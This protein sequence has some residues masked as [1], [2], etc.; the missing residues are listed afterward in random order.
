VSHCSSADKNSLPAASLRCSSTNERHLLLAIPQ[1][2]SSPALPFYSCQRFAVS[3]QGVIV[4]LL[5]HWN[6][7]YLHGVIFYPRGTSDLL[8]F[9]HVKSSRDRNVSDRRAHPP[10]SRPSTL[11]PASVR[12]HSASCASVS[13][14]VEHQPTL[15]TLSFKVIAKL[16]MTLT[17]SYQTPSHLATSARKDCVIAWASTFLSSQS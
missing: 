2:V 10:N 4:A 16:H 11:S 7:L 8:S 6:S 1:L 15:K 9:C 12:C 3:F 17:L 5:T 14:I 13:I